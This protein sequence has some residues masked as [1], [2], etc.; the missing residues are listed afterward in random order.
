MK[1]TIYIFLL[2]TIFSC[3]NLEIDF[4]ETTLDIVN[5]IYKGDKDNIVYLA[6]NLE[7][8]EPWY[9]AGEKYKYILIKYLDINL[10][11]LNKKN[12]NNNSVI[13]Y[14]HG[15]AFVYPLS[16]YY[17]N[18]ARFM[19]NIDDSFDIVFIDYR[20]L[21]D[22][23]YPNA[24]IDVDKG[25]DYVLSM[26]ENV[27]IMG[28]SAGGNLITSTLLKRKDENKKLPKAMV[29][30]SPFLDIS[31]SLD[32]RKRN[33]KVD[34]LIGNNSENYVLSKLLTNNPYFE[35]E[36]NKKDKYISP[37]FAEYNKFIPSY[38]E[39]NSTEVLYDDAYLLKEKLEKE[40]NYVEFYEEDLYHIYNLNIYTKK[41]KN[42]FERI[43]KFLNKIRNKEI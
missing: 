6:K 23:K 20:Q 22:Y 12:T 39:V 17:R 13:Y 40:N 41:T 14:V 38:I 7:K 1:K 9:D 36:I 43:Y 24:N 25:L 11:K 5:K 8:L 3:S 30:L 16:N 42:S 19:L 21:P 10:E 4:F 2:L 31:N 33:V 18:M 37:I 29:L 28:D 32:S 15:G 35:N 27:Y 26:Y 34:K